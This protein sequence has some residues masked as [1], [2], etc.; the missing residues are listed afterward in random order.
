MTVDLENSPVEPE[1]LFENEDLL[2][3]NKPAGLVVHG[4]QESDEGTL[5][6]WLL[7]ERPTIS[8]VGE[9]EARPGIVHRLDKETS[10]VIVVAKN[11]EAYFFLKAQF[12]GRSIEKRYQALVWGIVGEDRGQIDRPI[13]KGRGDVM[14]RT[15]GSGARGVLRQA[16]TY[17]KT[18]ERFP[19]GEVSF[20]E[21]YPKT[22]RTHQIRI[23]MRSIGH[24]VLCDRL[25]APG[26]VCPI[27]GLE[28]HA[29]HAA[30]L[31]LELRS[32]DRFTFTA[33]LPDDMEKAL[34]TLRARR[35]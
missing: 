31:T 19:L 33:P 6:S 17:W 32:G 10:G 35:S 11:N 4:D 18:V 5:V 16:L 25:Y 21:A 29:L 7:Q 15:V 34:K 28:R 2:V 24:P 3:L 27:V 9:S 23:H 14:V 13:G 1:I 22:G 26:K 8:G 20:L 30:S 12:Q